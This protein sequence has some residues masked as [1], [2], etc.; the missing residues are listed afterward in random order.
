MNGS[1][2]QDDKAYRKVLKLLYINSWNSCL[3]HEFYC[4][5]VTFCFS[6]WLVK[7]PKLDASFCVFSYHLVRG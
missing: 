2:L 6:P 7:H 5:T 1:W 3:F 4:K